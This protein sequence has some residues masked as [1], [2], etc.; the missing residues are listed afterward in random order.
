MAPPSG[1]PQVPSDVEALRASMAPYTSLA[2][3]KKAGY[4]TAITDCM[5]NGDDGAMGVH[6]GNTALIDGVADA[7]HPETLIYEPGKNGEM[8]LVGVE[9]LVPFTAVP[10]TSAAPVLF[11]QKFSPNDVFGVWGLHV[12][13]HRTNPSGLFASWNPRVHC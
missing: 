8:S 4:T 10:K 12:W 9:F 13:T 6:F 7:L 11:G 5:S 1:L 2:L 3:A